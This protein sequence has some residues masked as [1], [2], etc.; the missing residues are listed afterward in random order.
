LAF[1]LTAQDINDIR[2]HRAPAHTALDEPTLI[3]K[4]ADVRQEIRNLIIMQMRPGQPAAKVKFLHDMERSARAEEKLR[5]MA[6]AHYRRQE[7]PWRL[8]LPLPVPRPKSR[9]K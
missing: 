3:R 5:V 8:P 7:K 9:R 6:L 4:L 1:F 2:G